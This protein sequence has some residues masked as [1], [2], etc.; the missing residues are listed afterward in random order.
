MGQRTAKGK[1][2]GLIIACRHMQHMIEISMETEIECTGTSY[3]PTK[4]KQTV[5]LK[6]R[7]FSARVIDPCN[8]LDEET[9][10][11]VLPLIWERNSRGSWL[12]F[13]RR[14]WKWSYT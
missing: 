11:V 7:V 4:L 13:N 12:T 2:V 5:T 10:A 9:A 3:R 8:K 6:K 1:Y 14:T